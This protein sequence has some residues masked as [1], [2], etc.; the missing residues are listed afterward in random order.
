MH[1]RIHT[2]THTHTHTCTH[3]HTHTCTRTHIHMHKHT[4]A[5]MHVHAQCFWKTL[6]DVMSQSSSDPSQDD[7]AADGPLSAVEPPLT[8]AFWWWIVD[9]T[10]QLY[11]YD[12]T[13]SLTSSAQ[14]S[15]L[16]VTPPHTLL[17]GVVWERR[18]S[19]QLTIGALCCILLCV[20]GVWAEDWQLVCE[21]QLMKILEET[22]S[23]NTLAFFI[24]SL[25][26]LSSLWSPNLDVV[27]WFWPA[28][29]NTMGDCP[30]PKPGR[31][32][33]PAEGLFV[34][35]Q[36]V[37]SF[38]ARLCDGKGGGATDHSLF[39]QFT[40]L[41]CRMLLKL[42]PSGDVRK[43]IDKEVLSTLKN[44][45][46][47]QLSNVGLGNF[48][49]FHL[50][51]V[52]VNA[53]EDV[54]D[55]LLCRLASLRPSQ[56]SCQHSAQVWAALVALLHLQLQKRTLADPVVGGVARLLVE[57][58]ATCSSAVGH[59]SGPLLSA[60]EVVMRGVLELYR[61][62]VFPVSSAHLALF[63]E[64]LCQCIRS[65]VGRGRLEAVLEWVRSVVVAIGQHCVRLKEGEGSAE[66]RT[67]I[68]GESACACKLHH[69]EMM[70]SA[71]CN[72][73]TY[74]TPLFLLSS[75]LL[76]PL[77][78]SPP[79]SSLFLPPSLSS[80]LP[81]LSPPLVARESLCAVSPCPTHPEC[82]GPVPSSP[83]STHG[84]CH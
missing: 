64:P 21:L 8:A 11:R 36:E 49:L 73:T 72:I 44:E 51:L 27:L 9:W 24:A 3:T 5:H 57:L 43:K 28:V 29:K 4:H 17:P 74:S 50:S 2:H 33:S 13:G 83:S 42:A 6:S 32:L 54:G 77:P 14:A 67:R 18:V 16:G 35:P 12:S 38:V 59:V 47:L 58:A 81:F 30:L 39:L 78:S 71:L 52:C 34:S 66:E 76:S 10:A 79:S 70:L 41:L 80:L 46:L 15:P 62:T 63:S 22:C 82:P 26:R 56:P 45:D 7:C 68:Q 23:R 19:Q 60:V 84:L 40:A 65:L 31:H 55:L 61:Q 75:L 25:E 53:P 69:F 1:I 20:Q 48:I 37:A